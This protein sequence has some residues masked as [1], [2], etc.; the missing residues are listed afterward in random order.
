MQQD[1]QLRLI[2]ILAVPGLLLAHYLLLFHEGVLLLSCSASGW[3]DCGSVSGPT[4]QYAA[5]GPVPVALIGLIGYAAIFLIT[6]LKDWEVLRHRYLPELILGVTGCGFLFTIG[7][8]LL[9][10]F[11]LHA[12]CRYCLVS[13]GLI[14]ACFFLA[15]SYFRSVM[16]AEPDIYLSAESTEVR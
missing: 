11:V 9:E 13:A 4:A 15:V 16:K 5:V 1:W 2:Q 3:D 12:F 7:L 8:T 6:W 14:T 10:A